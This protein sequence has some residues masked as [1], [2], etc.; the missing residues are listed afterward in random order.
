MRN[1]IVTAAV[2][3]LAM[4]AGVCSAAGEDDSRTV[5]GLFD[6]NGSFGR[7]STGAPD[8]PTIADRLARLSLIHI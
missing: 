6:A 3:I 5:P 1:T 8:C 4:A 2:A 7:P